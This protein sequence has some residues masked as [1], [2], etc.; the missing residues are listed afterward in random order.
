MVHKARFLQVGEWINSGTKDNN[1][2]M[3]EWKLKDFYDEAKFDYYKIYK[4]VVKFIP[5]HNAAHPTGVIDA[6]G[7]KGAVESEFGFV[8]VDYDPHTAG[9]CP[10]Y[11]W[12]AQAQN[13]KVLRTGKTTTVVFKPKVMVDTEGG[14]TGQTASMLKRGWLN[15]KDNEVP[16]RGIMG[17][18]NSQTTGGGHS[19]QFGGYWVFAYA[20][21]L[22]QK[23]IFT[24][25]WTTIKK[26]DTSSWGAAA[27][28]PPLACGAEDA[29]GAKTE[30]M[31]TESAETLF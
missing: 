22:L 20:Y 4:M 25:A 8:S 6:T 27:P 19:N 23:P 3:F 16:H 29:C 11:S 31:D 5:K 15:M 26:W 14:Q 7:S 10:W 12:L 21:V 30:Y 28:Q 1:A 18:L 9:Q 13:H 24:A 17:W 2:K